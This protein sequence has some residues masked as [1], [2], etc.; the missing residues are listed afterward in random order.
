MKSYFH[1]RRYKSFFILLIVTAATICFPAIVL[2]EKHNNLNLVNSRSGSFPLPV[3]A[4]RLPDLPIFSLVSVTQAPV[5]ELPDWH[6]SRFIPDDPG[7]LDRSGKYYK[8]GIVQLFRGNLSLAY[9]RFQTVIDEYPDTKWFIPSRFWQGQILAQRKKY[10]QS[11]EALVLFLNSLKR[12][13]N[14]ES[15]IDFRNFS[16]YTLV[17]LA[18]KQKKYNDVTANIEKYEQEIDSGKIRS[19]LLYLKY[20]TNVKLNNKAEIRGV[21]KKLIKDFPNDFEH[22]V[23]LAEFYYAQ[24]NWKELTGLVAAYA[25][26]PDFYNDSQMEHFLWLGLDAQLNLKRWNEAKKIMRSLEKLGVQ[27]TDKLAKAYLKLNLH[28]KQIEQAWEDWLKIEDPILREQALRALIHRAVKVEEFEFLIKLEPELKRFNSFWRSWQDEVELIYAYIYL[29]IGQIEKSKRFLAS[30]YKHSLEE[31][32]AQSTIVNEESLYLS[33]VV[34]LISLNFQRA[35]MLIKQ[36][37]ESY[38]DSVRLS[39]YY[40]WY[41]VLQYEIEKNSM[42]TIMAMRQVDRNGDRDD[43]R[44]FLLAKVNHDQQKWAAVYLSLAKLK[45]QYPDSPFL[46]E[47]LYLQSHASF[48]QRQYNPALEI[49]NELQSAFDPIKKPVRAIHL[50]VRI[51]MAM[52]RYEQAD[53]VLKRSIEGHSDF[54]L[55]KLRIEVL[56]HINDPIRILSVTNRGLGLSI[57]KDQGFLFLH[58]ANALYEMKHYEQAYTV[59]KFALVNPPKNTT[60][61]INYRILKTHFELEKIDELEQGAD[62]FLAEFKDDVYSYEILHLLSDYFLQ[63]NQKEKAKPYLKQLVVNYEKSVRKVELAPDQRVEQIIIIGE[64]YNELAEYEK[65]VLWLNHALKAMET[66]EDGRKKWQ[67]RILRVKGIALYQLGKHGKALAASLKVL[68]LDRSLSEQQLYDLNLR[69]ASS[70][71]Q[72]KRKKEAKAIYRKMLKNF[73]KK[74]RRKEIETLLG[75]L[76]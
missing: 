12:V 39:E 60:R 4:L 26:K 53:E 70:Y 65:A 13:P 27:S 2:A 22:I 36:L 30:S 25:K 17:W 21:L 58:R 55:I 72:S 35:F 63:R 59:Y 40:F 64:L 68:Y 18:F 37:L 20:L 49:L 52:Q 8:E 6:S 32:D 38:S 29:R 42:Q 5:P 9:M 44:L 56:K 34:E 62:I 73:T 67:L 15:Y 10:A 45:K 71:V 31:D 33:T 74:E 47:S 19:K 11:A 3:P 75:N 66:V 41:G 50:R 7:W 43:D 46:Q 1:E 14:P 51:L 28:T 48:E 16:R 76:N 69:I 54:S 61:F 24:K 23:L 57:S